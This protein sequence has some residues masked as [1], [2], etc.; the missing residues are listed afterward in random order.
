M[1]GASPHLG[2]AAGA[3]ASSSEAILI[4]GPVKNPQANGLVEAVAKQGRPVAVVHDRARDRGAA[5]RSRVVGAIV[6]TG[7]RY[8]TP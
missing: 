2:R 3:G 6:S 4:K 1:R 8:R 7:S 5:R